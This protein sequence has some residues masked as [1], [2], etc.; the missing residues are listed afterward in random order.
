MSGRAWAGLA[1]ALRE[2]GCVPDALL[3]AEVRTPRFP[4]TPAGSF[5]DSAV[6]FKFVATEPSLLLIRILKSLSGAPTSLQSVAICSLGPPSRCA[7]SVPFRGLPG[8]PR[9]RFFAEAVAQSQSSWS[10]QF[11]ES[12]LLP[13]PKMTDLYHTPSMATSE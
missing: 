7:G 5:Q 3:A 12:R 4:P 11:G 9:L 6:L 1:N 10:D 8:Q 2:D 13:A